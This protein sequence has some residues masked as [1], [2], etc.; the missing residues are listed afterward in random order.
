MF[1]N[2]PSSFYEPSSVSASW[3]K[4]MCRVPLEVLGIP[5]GIGCV[6]CIDVLARCPYLPPET[7]CCEQVGCNHDSNRKYF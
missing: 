2:G 1:S 4:I 7:S 6:A 3:R 5:E